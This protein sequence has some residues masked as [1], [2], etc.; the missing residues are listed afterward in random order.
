MSVG[1]ALI[2]GLRIFDEYVVLALEAWEIAWFATFWAI[3]TR[4]NWD[5]DP[6]VD[7]ARQAVDRSTPAPLGT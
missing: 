5:E 4:E 3:Q 7:A 2:A 1:G 6:V